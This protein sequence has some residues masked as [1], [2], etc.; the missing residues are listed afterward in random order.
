MVAHE[1][2]LKLWVVM[3]RALRS[4]ED[5]LREQVE[6]HDLSL[7]E[8][9]VLEVLLHKGDLPIGEIGDRILRTSGSMTYVLDKLQERDL[10]RR[11][12]CPE[13][14][15]VLYA[16]LTP[17]GRARIETVFPEHAALIGELTSAL[18]VDEQRRATELLKQVGLFA[19]RWTPD[20]ERA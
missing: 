20:E 14:R 5:R 11:R 10:I 7:T 3:N 15:R 8:F 16:E 19:E 18:D 6:A 4:I 13:D 2:A 17:K 9:A 1:A 12:R